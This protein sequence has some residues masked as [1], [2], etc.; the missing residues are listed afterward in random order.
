MPEPKTAEQPFYLGA[1]NVI[2]LTANLINTIARGQD[3]LGVY[4]TIQVDQRGCV[5]LSDADVERIAQ[6]V[7]ELIKGVK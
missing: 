7:M 6:K 4:N 1:P 3:S 2:D 5:I